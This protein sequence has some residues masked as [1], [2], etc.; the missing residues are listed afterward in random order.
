MFLQSHR[1]P[2]VATLAPA[3]HRTG[4]SESGW[5]GGA[6]EIQVLGPVEV[7][8]QG[9]SLRLTRRQQWLLLGI[10]ALRVNRVVSTEQLIDL[11]WG[12]WPARNARATLQTRVFTINYPHALRVGTSELRVSSGSSGGSGN[13]GGNA[14]ASTASPANAIKAPRTNTGTYPKLCATQPNPSALTVVPR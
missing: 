13:T 6:V 5:I 9:A 11:L 7:R 14:S 3:N 10:L 1:Q 2:G 8:H 12:D 4:S